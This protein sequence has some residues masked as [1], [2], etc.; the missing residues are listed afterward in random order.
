MKVFIYD[1]CWYEG[2]DTV[3]ILAESEEQAN[4]L[5]KEKETG[6]EDYTLI[7]VFSLDEKPGIK[8]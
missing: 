4:S 8:Y 3:V 1:E 6:E 5:L 7:K 2:C